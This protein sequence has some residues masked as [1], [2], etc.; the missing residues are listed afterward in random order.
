MLAPRRTIDCPMSKKETKQELK[1]LYRS[2]TAS[3]CDSVN[4]LCV[5]LNLDANLVVLCSFVLRRS[6]C[7]VWLSD[8]PF[9][10]CM[11]LDEINN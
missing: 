3:R 10:Q 9:K 2:V 6:V 1:S 11:S 5:A 7:P 4:Y 8:C